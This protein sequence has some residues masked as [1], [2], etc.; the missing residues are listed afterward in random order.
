M[1]T[2]PHH[3][4]FLSDRW[5]AEGRRFLAG[6]VPKIRERPAPAERLAGRRFSL[7]G[8]F[9][10][11]PPHMKLPGD[12]GCVTVHFD[13]EAFEVT[14][15]FDPTANLVIEGDYQAALTGAQ[16]VG[17][18]APDASETL[19]REV[20][21]LYGAEALKVRG[22]ISDPLTLHVLGTLFDHLGRM[23]VENPD[24]AHRAARQGLSGKIREMADQGYVIV[25]NAITPEFADEA[26]E[27]ILRTLATH[28]HS[29]MNW[30]LYHGRALE[31]LALNPVLMTLIDASLGR[32]A[33]IGSLSAIR[34]PAGPG[35][36]PIHTDYS[37]VPEPYPDF[38][39]TG[40]G[41]WA[42]EDW[43][44]ESLRSPRCSCRA[45]TGPGATRER[46]TIPARACRS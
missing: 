16:M 17:I 11:P 30:M 22:G 33:V 29:T 35:F 20:A 2:L 37:H 9:T 13:G 6:E 26:R 23:T 24:L 45:A 43:T 4:E 19:R 39:M 31:R 7:S 32:G 41:V 46:P 27:A 5:L 10:Q 3:V 21:H 25:E 15:T 1:F 28:G 40:V 18:G 8:R 36:I 12:V 44:A 14:S 42:F 34:R 38:A